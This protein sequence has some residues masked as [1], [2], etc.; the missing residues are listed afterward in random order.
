MESE[1]AAAHGAFRS[2]I[3]FELPRNDSVHRGR[4]QKM[5]KSYPRLKAKVKD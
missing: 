4:M 1:D 3:I 2:L 5:W